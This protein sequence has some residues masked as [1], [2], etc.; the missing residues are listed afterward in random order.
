MA[1]K[2]KE[3]LFLPRHD[4][5][6]QFARGNAYWWKNVKNDEGRLVGRAVE[7][8]LSTPGSVFLVFQALLPYL[9][10]STTPDDN[11]PDDD[12]TTQA[13]PITL[14]LHGGTNVPASP[15]FEYID[16]VLL[17]TLHR[18]GIPPLTLTLHNRGW[19][20]GR[21]QIG[22][23]TFTITPLPPGSTLPAFSLPSREPTDMVKTVHVS[24]LAPTAAVRA[25]IRSAVTEAVRTKYGDA[26]EIEVPVDEDSGHAKRLYLLLVAETGTGR[27]Y[28]RDWLYDRKIAD[29]GDAAG[30]MVAKVVKDLAWEVRSRR[31]VDSFMEDQLVVFMALGEGKS[32]LGDGR[33]R[34]QGPQEEEARGGKREG[35]GNDEGGSRRVGESQEGRTGEEQEESLKNEKEKEQ[36]KGTKPT[37]HTLTARWVAE[38]IL[39]V[40][41][42]NINHSHNH[43]DSDSDSGRGGTCTGY[44]FSS[45]SDKPKPK[46]T[47]QEVGTHTDTLADEMHGLSI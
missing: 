27:R 7:I 32:F 22:S 30:R 3:L 44:A 9:L 31:A 16:Q 35:E 15:S 41:F 45:N 25:Q 36:V 19:T 13:L 46:P 8:K 1:L 2:S 47:S 34:G 5:N 40:K 29:A 20:H 38:K 4:E 23:V 18:I 28:G 17:P 14:T 11:S 21:A 33:G 6:E 43:N 42:D 24:I 37:L 39:D 26:V 10:F 12:P